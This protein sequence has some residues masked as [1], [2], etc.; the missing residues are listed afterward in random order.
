MLSTVHRANV[1]SFSMA[2]KNLPPNSH[3]VCSQN[4]FIIVKKGH[5]V[6]GEGLGLVIYFKKSC[7]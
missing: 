1:V 6:L 3:A 4:I 2:L 5:L 7:R